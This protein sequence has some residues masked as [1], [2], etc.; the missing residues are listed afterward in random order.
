MS[1]NGERVRLGLIG[2]GRISRA[3]V[4]AYTELADHIKVVA[5]AEPNET[6]ASAARESL[7]EDGEA[8]RVYSDWRQ[9]LEQR[10]LEAVD[11]CLPHDLHAPVCVAAAEASMHVLVEKPIAR[12]LAEA[13]AMIAAAERAGVLLMVCHDRR[14]APE[15]VAI[16]DLVDGGAIGQLLCLRLDHNQYIRVGPTDWIFQRRRLGGGAIM[17]CLTHQLD[18]IRW[19]GGEVA[20]VGCVSL[21]LPDRMEGEIIG[22]VPLRFASGAVGDA[23]INWH[24][25]GHGLPGGLWTEHV[26]LS[27]RD[28]NIHNWN[29]VHVL[30]HETAAQ[31]YAART[32]PAGT[33]HT[34]AIAHFAACVRNGAAPLTNGREA[35]ASLEVALAA[36]AA[37]ESGRF[38]TLPLSAADRTEVDRL[39]AQRIE[40][41]PVASVASTRSATTGR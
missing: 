13:D 14:Y 22:V 26:W 36:H 7:G 2:A 6:A 17:S 40:R 3:H 10:D 16:K 39:A 32:V 4:R 31:G 9:L 21:T 38:I 37:E 23:V 19:Y 1:I 33:G 29:G 11:V 34:G 5:I 27:G 15:L 24:M 30:R 28:G 18:L 41:D 8:C 12:D 25:Q 20:Q 35:R